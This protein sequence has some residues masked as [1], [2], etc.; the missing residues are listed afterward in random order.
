MGGG[1]KPGKKTKPAKPPATKKAPTGK[2]AEAMKE[3]AM[4][5]FR[6]EYKE[7]LDH[8]VLTMETADAAEREFLQGLPGM[9]E[10]IRMR[11]PVFVLFEGDWNGGSGFPPPS[12]MP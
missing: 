8:P 12:M 1:K 5:V 11:F 6:K 2:I 7:D 4:E 9:G 10:T 3:A